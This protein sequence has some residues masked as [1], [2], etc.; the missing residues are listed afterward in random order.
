MTVNNETGIIPP[1]LSPDHV[2][3]SLSRKIAPRHRSDD[4]TKVFDGYGRIIDCGV[5]T[6]FGF[7]E[8]ENAKDAED[9]LRDF[10]NKPFMGAKNMEDLVVTRMTTEG[11]PVRADLKG[12]AS[13]FRTFTATSAGR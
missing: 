3:P 7:I 11:L 9:A 2:S 1:Q 13:S 4:V 5:M 10:A 12:S 8:Y 6:G